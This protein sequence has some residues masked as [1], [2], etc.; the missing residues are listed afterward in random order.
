MEAAKR[1]ISAEV[2]RLG[3]ESAAEFK[4]VLHRKASPQGGDPCG[5]ELAVAASPFIQPL[6]PLVSPR[7]LDGTAIAVRRPTPPSPLGS[8]GRLLVGQGLRGS[9]ARVEFKGGPLAGSALQLAAGRDGVH[10]QLFAAGEGARLALARVV[11]RVEARLRARGIL[12]NA[13]T[14]QARAGSD[15]GGREQ[16]RR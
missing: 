2:A 4:R 10:V 7:A 13:A 12:M 3:G 5:R 9:Q 6:Q 8:V 11:D 16:R 14:D 1:G 15:R